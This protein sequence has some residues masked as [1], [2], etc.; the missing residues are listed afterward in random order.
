MKKQLYRAAAATVLGLSLTTGVV[1][2]DTGNISYTGPNSSNAIHTHRTNKV[3]T[4]RTRTT[5]QLTVAGPKLGTT[6]TV[7]ML[8]VVMPAILTALLPT[9]A[10]TTVLLVA[11]AWTPS[12]PEVALAVVA[13]TPLVPTRLTASTPPFATR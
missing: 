6:L 9:L 11:A 12:T 10:L 5:S 8:P 13:S 1:A 4:Y 7:A 3:L 2:A